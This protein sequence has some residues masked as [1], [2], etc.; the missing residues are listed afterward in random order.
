MKPLTRDITFTLIVKL[1]LLFLLWWF[2][3]RGMHPLLSTSQDWFLGTADAKQS[4][5]K[6]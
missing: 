6:R 2:C 4:I 3:V 5:N 1:L